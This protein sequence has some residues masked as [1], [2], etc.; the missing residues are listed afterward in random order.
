[1]Q[2]ECQA[3]FALRCLG[4]FASVPASP[5]VSSRIDQL[6]FGYRDG[7]ELLA[8]SVSIDARRQASLLPHTDAR[9][10]DG[11]EHYLVGI[12]L[13]D[14]DRYLLAR[15]WP[16]PEI[17]RPGAVWTHALL[18]PLDA[19]GTMDPAALT[20]LFR[21]PGDQGDLEGYEKPLAWPAKSRSTPAGEPSESLALAL[22]EAIYGTESVSAVVIWSPA[23]E[24]E[25]EL[26]VAWQRLPDQ[27]RSAFS[28]RTRGKARTGGGPYLIQIASKLAGRSESSSEVDVIDPKRRAAASPPA[29]LSLIVSATREPETR[30]GDF[31]TSYAQQ[32]PDSAA[33]ARVWPGIQGEEPQMV[34]S[35]L[36]AAYP[37]PEGMR[38]LKR[39]LFGGAKKFRSLWRVHEAPRLSTLLS[40]TG[41]AFDLKDLKVV[42]RLAALWDG[43][44]RGAAIELLDERGGLAAPAARLVLDSAIPKISRD[45]LLKRLGD[46]SLVNATAPLRMDIL[47][48]SKFWEAISAKQ[49]AAILE[50][51]PAALDHDE[52]LEALIDA[53]AFVALAGALRHEGQMIRAATALSKRDPRDLGSWRRVFKGREFELATAL[54]NAPR[55]SGSCLLLAFAFLDVAEANRLDW[56]RMFSAAQQTHDRDDSASLIAAAMLFARALPSKNATARKILIETFGPVHFGLEADSLSDRKALRELDR[57]L[58]DAKSRNRAK[59]LRQ[60]LV[61]RMERDRWTQEDFER[62]VGPSGVEPKQFMKLVEK[63]HPARR[64]VEKAFEEITAPLRN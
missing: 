27:D 19:V 23:S 48:Q 6:L 5:P 46:R 20:G 25:D 1:M 38:G 14:L 64:F 63:K 41:E 3:S 12:P 16:A 22:G 45:E 21:R 49:A 31:L 30:F 42:P 52:P 36:G 62:A 50:A 59:R 8:S 29:W 57:V 33:L 9:F 55:V 39:E 53:D 35:E 40:A 43:S 32:R 26:L 2:T 60:A 51:A 47:G 17:S 44:D 24:A 54:E 58:P 61:K 18:L 4:Y 11:S 37:S 13:A 28:F 15:I 56:P 10:D 34:I 7:H